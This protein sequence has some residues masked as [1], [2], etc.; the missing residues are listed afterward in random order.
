MK[1][2]TKRIADYIK[3]QITYYTT[4][5]MNQPHLIELILTF[6][7]NQKCPHCDSQKIKGTK[8]LTI[9][10]WKDIVKKI[11]RWLGPKPIC[12]AGGEPLLKKGVYDLVSSISKNNKVYIMTNGQHDEKT[13]KRLVESNISQILISFYSLNPRI[14]DSIRGTKEAHKRAKNFIEEL[15]KE[16]KK[17]KKDIRIDLS[18]LLTSK[19]FREAPAFIKHFSKKEIY[20]SL[21]PLRRNPLDIFS[22]DFKFYNKYWY[23][24]S[25]LWINDK[26]EFVKIIKKIICMKKKGYLIN[27]YINTLKK[28]V[29]YFENPSQLNK[30]NCY[31]PLLNF[32]IGP[33]GDV[34]LC[35]YSRNIGNVI[36]KD[37]KG[38]W[39]SEERMNEIKRLKK[40]TNYCRI[41]NNYNFINLDEKIRFLFE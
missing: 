22:E 34:R 26:E 32:V 2:K 1:Q 6:R 12:L 11:N 17:Q 38:I 9:N 23:K 13:A 31:M 16:K 37:P 7:C 39:Y 25:S 28:F 33:M 36:K 24:K 19:N 21:T 8:E 4:T 40:C 29:D 3:N 30:F 14:H 18:F 35:Y 5:S 41:H 15:L 10:Q 27:N 20:T